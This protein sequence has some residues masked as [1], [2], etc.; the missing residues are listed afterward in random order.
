M[1]NK[2]T[3]VIGALALLL[4]SSAAVAQVPIRPTTPEENTAAA[5]QARF[6]EREYLK[7]ALFGVGRLPKDCVYEVIDPSGEYVRGN[8][9]IVCGDGDLVLTLCAAHGVECDE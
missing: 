2:R 7:R 6:A 1:K 5:G 9:A 8:L 3:G 4:V